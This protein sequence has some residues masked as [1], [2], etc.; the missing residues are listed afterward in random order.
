M[1]T[2]EA[3]WA[4][5]Q[6]MI[7]DAPKAIPQMTISCSQGTMK[8]PPWEASP[9]PPEVNSTQERDTPITAPIT[10]PERATKPDSKTK[11]RATIER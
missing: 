2:R 8:D 6:V 3:L 5:N 11:L 7:I 10:I 9:M 1:A 4:G